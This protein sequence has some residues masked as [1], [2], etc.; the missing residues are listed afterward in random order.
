MI[1][2]METAVVASG[3]ECPDTTLEGLLD[4][5]VDFPGDARLRLAYEYG[6]LSLDVH[7]RRVLQ[8]ITV[9][10]NH[11]VAPRSGPVVRWEGR[12]R[13]LGTPRLHRHPKRTVVIAILMRTAVIAIPIQD[14]PLM[15]LGSRRVEPERNVVSPTVGGTGAG[16]QP[17]P[18]TDSANESLWANA[19]DR[20]SCDPVGRVEG[21]DGIIEGRE[22]ADV[23][24]QSPVAHAL[25]N[26]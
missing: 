25:D 5:N 19:D 16:R 9:V 20:L 26:L 23:P 4:Q 21:R 7:G 14:S 3:I 18:R 13:G 12:T 6:L 8:E 17:A 24:P 22:L 10:F 11:R 2:C 1:A 15:Q